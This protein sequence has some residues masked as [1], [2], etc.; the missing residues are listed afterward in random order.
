MR[1]RRWFCY[2]SQL[3]ES[4]CVQSVCFGTGGV[5]GEQSTCACAHRSQPSRGGAFFLPH[6]AGCQGKEHPLHKHCRDVV[7][8]YSKPVVLAPAEGFLCSPTTLTM[9]IISMR[10]SQHVLLP[11]LLSLPLRFPYK[12]FSTTARRWRL[13]IC[14][15]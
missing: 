5:S 1:V 15:T 11:R 8:I 3:D 6:A 14:R 13:L 10:Y 4:W 2:V 12:Q 7:H 9:V